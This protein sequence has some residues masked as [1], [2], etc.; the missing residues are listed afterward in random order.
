MKG[1]IKKL[2]RVAKRKSTRHHK[3]S[4]ADIMYRYKDIPDGEFI[5]T[6]IDKYHPP[7]RKSK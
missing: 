3:E 2:M 4:W 7:R 6:L 5:D 1:I